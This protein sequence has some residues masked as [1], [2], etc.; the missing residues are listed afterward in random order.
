M[1]QVAYD[2]S[3]HNAVSLTGNLGKE[4]D[5]RQLPS[6]KIVGKFSLAVAAGKDNTNWW[7]SLV[8]GCAPAHSY[9]GRDWSAL[10][11]FSMPCACHNDAPW[12]RW[13]SQCISKCSM[14]RMCNC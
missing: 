11:A 7:V 13:E 8:I 6:G 1:Q 10:P 2:A 5:V 12:W 3:K 14:H 9:N 4:P